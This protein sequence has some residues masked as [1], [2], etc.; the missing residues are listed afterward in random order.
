MLLLDIW[1]VFHKNKNILLYVTYN[2]HSKSANY[3]DTILLSM[4]LIQILPVGHVMS[5]KI[6]QKKKKNSFPEFNQIKSYIE[7]YR[8][9][10]L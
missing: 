8:F 7:F 3:S 2:I 4:D 9:N 1:I 10:I 5:S 6:A